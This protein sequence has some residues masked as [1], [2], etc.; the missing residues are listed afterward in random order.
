MPSAGLATAAVFGSQMTQIDTVNATVG[1]RKSQCDRM[2]FFVMVASGRWPS[3]VLTSVS[4]FGD[5]VGPCYLGGV[6]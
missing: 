2:I 3:T 5:A 1:R 4:Y 6:S